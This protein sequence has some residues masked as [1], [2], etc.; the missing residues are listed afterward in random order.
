M[1][2]DAHR[3][4]IGRVNAIRL[5]ESGY[6]SDT[7]QQEWDERYL[8]FAREVLIHLTKSAGVRFPVVGRSLHADEQHG[9]AALFCA[10]DNAL[11]VLFH[12]RGRQ[13]AKAVV[14]AEGQ[15]QHPHVAFKRPGCAPR[16]VGGR[17]TRDTRVDDL[18]IVPGVFQFPLQQS[19]IRL[20]AREA[21]TR[22][23]AVTQHDDAG[24][25]LYGGR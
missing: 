9:N 14:G 18:Q 23:E 8:V 3:A 5:V 2:G 19:R 17:V 16:S 12:L 7:L 24:R 11:K 4:G 22:G 10:V 21:K 20:F 6:A 25:C 15:D 1:I 13:P